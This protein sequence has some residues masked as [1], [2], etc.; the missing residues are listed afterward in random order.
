MA[1][2]N[3]LNEDGTVRMVDVGAKN[4]TERRAVA[5]ADVTMQSA[6]SDRLFSGDLPKG[7]ALATVRIAAI[8]ATKRTPDLIPLCHP[9]QLT[10]VDVSIARTESGAQ[11][12]VEARLMGRTGVEMEAMTGAAVGA[13]ALYD[14]VKGID[15]SALISS[16][17][18]LHKSGGKSGEWNRD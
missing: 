5:V 13:L 8:Q 6:T 16:V 1:E 2:M 10:G 3:H 7:D 12:S 18:L 11:I 17:R 15:R 9:L 14:M 4:E